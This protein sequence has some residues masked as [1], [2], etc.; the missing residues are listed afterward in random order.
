MPFECEDLLLGKRL[1]VLLPLTLNRSIVPIRVVDSL[2]V[3]QVNH[4]DGARVLVAPSTSY[5][6]FK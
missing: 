1:P 2:K 6:T 5:F 4:Y 3:V